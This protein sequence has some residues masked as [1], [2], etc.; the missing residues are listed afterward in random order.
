MATPSA[1][2]IVSRNLLSIGALSIDEFLACGPEQFQFGLEA[3]T[4]T[5]A[6]MIA[7]PMQAD[8]K[9]QD[10]ELDDIERLVKLCERLASRRY[11]GTETR[12]TTL[13][14]EFI[15]D[16]PD[17]KQCILTI[18]RPMGE[19]RSYKSPST[20]TSNED[21]KL[22]A[23]N[24]A[25]EH[26][27]LEFIE[28]GDSDESKAVKG[29]LLVS[30][31]YEEKQHLQIASSSEIKPETAVER[32]EASCAQRR[33]DAVQPIWYTF[34]TATTGLDWIGLIHGKVPLTGVSNTH[35]ACLKM[36]LTLHN[37][38]VYS[39]EP[40]FGSPQKAQEACA[41][42]AIHEGVLDFISY[43]SDQTVPTPMNAPYDMATSAW[44]LQSFFESIPRPL[45]EDFGSRNAPQIQAV[46]WLEHVVAT[47]H[48][49]RFNLKKA[50]HLF[51]S[52]RSTPHPQIAYGCLLRLKRTG[53]Q[54][55]VYSY[56]VEPQAT[57]Q[58]EAKAA[59]ALLALSLGAGKLI[60]EASAACQALISPEVRQFTGKFVLSVLG[61]ETRRASDSPPIFGYSNVDGATGC[62]LTV[63]PKPRPSSP[64]IYTVPAQYVSKADAKIAVAYLAA[65][66]GVVDLL[67]CNGELPPPGYIN[68]FVFPPGGGVPSGPAWSVQVGGGGKK[69]KKK[70][71]LDGPPEKKQR[72]LSGGVLLGN[73]N[74]VLA[75]NI[76]RRR[77]SESLEEGELVL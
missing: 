57:T 43:K 51:V 7:D 34:D 6:S 62:T 65:Q 26:G 21:A 8:S 71:A 44:T 38:R 39:C 49:A 13:Q 19:S 42:L 61:V 11:D 23:A 4:P 58:K 1:F 46:G 16:K 12:Q 56:L 18:T 14:F 69:R 74:R 53:P 37:Y 2:E 33:G 76:T 20:F 45:E 22:S 32:I 73:S 63:Y 48:G 68:A 9:L 31:D 75:Y 28:F 3:S 54:E 30:L 41:E 50:Y 15:E 35:G 52:P 59:V 47:A 67:R 5:T 10:S 64:I 17:T 29:T 24:I 25:I 72:V 66:Q 55:A 70:T 77:R 40:V 60:R 27:A 36:Q